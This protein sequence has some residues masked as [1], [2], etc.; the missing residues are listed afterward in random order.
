MGGGYRHATA[1]SLAAVAFLAVAVAAGS[2]RGA[3]SRSGAPARISR[4]VASPGEAALLWRDLGLRGRA[5]LLFDHYPHAEVGAGMYSGEPASPDALVEYGV[6]HNL[7]RRV[8]LVVPDDRWEDFRLQA[9]LY[10]ILR[11]VPGEARAVE[12]FTFSGAPMIAL[13]S[14]ALPRL[15]EQVLVYVNADAF[16][17]AWVAGRLAAGSIESDVTVVRRAG[18]GG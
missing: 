5:L 7:V 16:D 3:R 1:W 13:A 6:F 15:R 9:Q 18:G 12:L 14:D 4:V 8:Y 2:L 17:P 11:P 10:K